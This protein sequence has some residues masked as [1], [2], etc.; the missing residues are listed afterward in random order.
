[1]RRLAFVFY[2]SCAVVLAAEEPVS[3]RLPQPF[4][5]KGE[6]I[7]VICKVPRNVENRGLT[8]GVE[9]EMSSYRQLDGE[10]AVITHTLNVDHITCD[11][12]LAYCDLTT[13]NGKTRRVA[14]R[15][16]VLGCS[17]SD[18]EPFDAP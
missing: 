15:I 4:A 13:S 6:M 1:M 18:D 14:Q 7:R 3:I 10:A 12:G 9:N 5:M 2:A 16:K 11:A 8:L 17:T